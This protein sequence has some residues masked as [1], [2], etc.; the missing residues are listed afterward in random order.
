MEDVKVTLN[1]TNGQALALAQFLKR[2]DHDAIV[3]YAHA[4]Q[5]DLTTQAF[6]E[7]REALKNMGFNPR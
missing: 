2:V 6:Q 7:V 4:D 1:L 3:R 5:Q